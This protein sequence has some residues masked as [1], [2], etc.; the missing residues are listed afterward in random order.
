MK[1]R[2]H[3]ER[4]P[5][6]QWNPHWILGMLQKIWM[7][8]FAG[9]KI[10]AGAVATVLLIALI[11]GF[12]FAG[13]FADY[14]EED[15]MPSAGM[16]LGGYDLD[17]TSFMY[18]VTEDGQI[19]TLQ[20]IYATTSRK[21][22]TLEEIPEDLI[23]A[24]VAIEDKRFYEHQGVD[25]FTTVKAFANMFFGDEVVGG[26]SITQQLIKNMTQ[27]DSVTVQRKVLE[28]FRASKIE[29][30]YDKNVII[31]EYL[32]TIYLGQGCRGVKSAA[33][34]YFGKELRMLTTAECASLIGI[35]NNPS[36]YDPYMP[37]FVEGGRTGW[38]RNKERKEI[39]LGEM[40]N[41]NWITQEEYEEAMAQELVL[42][43]SIDDADRWAEC[44]NRDCDYENLVGTYIKKDNVYTCPKCNQVT[45][46]ADDASQEVYSWFVD[47]V[48][49]DVAM[50]MA[51]KDGVTWNDETAENYKA[52][53]GKGGYHIYTTLD[54]EAQ[55]AVDR[56]Y[57]DLS[58]IP[59]TWSA[60]QL[61]SGIVLI[62]NRTGD[63][64]A[65]AGGVGEKTVF[66]AHSIATDAKLQSGSSIKPLTIY[67]PAFELDSFTPA[68]VVKDLPFFYE[69]N[70]DG[71]STTPWPNNDDRRYSYAR[72]IYS[73]ITD[74]VNAAATNTLSMIGT[75]YG[76]RFAK[77]NFGLSTLTDRYVREDGSIAT[78]IDY[79]PLAMGAQ[80]V[81]VTVRDMASAFA[82]FANEGIYRSGRTF[83]KVYDTDGNLILDNTQKTNAVVSKKTADYINY[84]LINAVQNGTGKEARINGINVAGKTGSTSSFRD[85]WFCGYTEYYTAAVWCGYRS[86]EVINLKD[87]SYNPAA[88]LW[89][90]V[91]TPLHEGKSAGELYDSRKMISVDICLD[92]GK[93]ATDACRH[94]IRTS[95]SFDRVQEVMVYMEDRPTQMCDKHVTVEYCQTGGGVATE[96]CKHFAEAGESVSLTQSALV[97]LTNKQVAD[98]L[99]AQNWGLNSVYLQDNYVYLVNSA[100]ADDSFKGFHNNINQGIDA[101]YQV[102]KTHT[103]KAWEDYLKTHPGAAGQSTLDGILDWLNP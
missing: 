63:I 86:P 30:R 7:V 71:N 2:N 21:L 39:I 97:K 51:E 4:K 40:R 34:T 29:K 25:W 17:L 64:V 89:R 78:D 22:A 18:Y 32:N 95:N 14:L 23:H 8:F 99:A 19:E 56:I 27:E 12:V 62:D 83:T 77:E 3:K 72:T 94:D 16:D 26:S 73:A 92:S 91:M 76:Y 43:S 66:D 69:K 54:M 49:E 65:M 61:E 74:S 42:K 103:A 6:Q 60:Q 50:A 33:A 100:G 28:F 67:A 75:G 90:K 79:A 47:T 93:L 35:T 10:V 55:N 13:T 82:T 46:I 41:Q 48:L 102:C 52:L 70:E 11:C 80:T 84:C 59:D 9:L 15:I 37:A 87:G 57:Q 31:T 5:E 44:T 96:Y 98:I 81:G 85:R 88:R 20:Q 58:Q 36:L 45:D 24:A 101:P 1:N 68:T 38:Q 53:I